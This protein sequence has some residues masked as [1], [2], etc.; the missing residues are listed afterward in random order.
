M[1]QKC[2]ISP[3]MTTAVLLVVMVLVPFGIALVAAAGVTYYRN[4]G[5]K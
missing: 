1:S 4:R 2:D 3:E 5:N